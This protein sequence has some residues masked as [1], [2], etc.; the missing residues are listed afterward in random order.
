MVS[1]DCHARNAQAGT[2]GLGMFPSV[3]SLADDILNLR[4]SSGSLV[5][6]REPLVGAQVD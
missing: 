6:L 5:H 1:S 2:T 4:S 3:T